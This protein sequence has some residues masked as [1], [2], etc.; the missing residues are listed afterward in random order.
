MVEAIFS[1]DIGDG[2]QI[3]S[4]SPSD[5][6]DD[7]GA[8]QGNQSQRDP[9]RVPAPKQAGNEQLSQEQV[10]QLVRFS[11]LH[12]MLGKFFVSNQT[13][14]HFRDI[15]EYRLAFFRCQICRVDQL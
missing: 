13:H 5:Q 1:N 14:R 2:F 10:G 15:L 8:K 6:E 9:H 11:Q 3:P 4:G 12:G 7:P